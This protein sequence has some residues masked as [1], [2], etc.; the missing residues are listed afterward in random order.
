VV[1]VD[2]GCRI[3]SGC[4]DGRG[5]ALQQVHRAG[6]LVEGAGARLRRRAAR[7]RVQLEHAAAAGYAEGHHEALQAGGH[8]EDGLQH[9][10]LREAAGHAHCAH[11]GQE[12]GQSE[13]QPQ[14]QPPPP[15]H[16]CL[17]R[18]FRL[19]QLFLRSDQYAYVSSEYRLK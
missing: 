19:I 9:G 1:V 13:E 10:A 8:A 18:Y 14:L 16:L 3:P 2:E 4:S 12:G 11:H 5:V 15:T 7:P 17:K 6:G